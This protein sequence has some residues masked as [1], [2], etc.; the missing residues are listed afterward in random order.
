M[1]GGEVILHYSGMRG[2]D[3]GGTE[4]IDG[5]DSIGGRDRMRRECSGRKGEHGGQ[6]RMHEERAWGKR[7]QGG[8]ESMKGRR[9]LE[10]RERET[11]GKIIKSIVMVL[12]HN[13]GFCNGGIT[14][15]V[16]A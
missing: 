8:G 7:G 10:G 13:N 9:S 15:F 1:S 2:R 5:S 16:F 14:K 3:I 6:R 11:D 12:L 4:N